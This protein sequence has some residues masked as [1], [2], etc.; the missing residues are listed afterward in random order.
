MLEKG[1][2]A[3]RAMIFWAALVGVLVSALALG[4]NR[5]VSWTA[6]WAG[7][8]MLFTALIVVDL[9]ASSATIAWRRALPALVLWTLVLVWGLIQAGPAPIAG[10]AH[11]AWADVAVLGAL[12]GVTRQTWPWEGPAEGAAV[13][14]ISADP[15]ATL[16]GVMRLSTYLMLFWIGARGATDR[17]ARGA[18]Q[19]VAL[20]GVALAI[21]GMVALFA[22][23]NPITGGEHYQ[24]TVTAS[25]VNR[26]AYAFYAGIG[27]MAC[28]AALALRLPPPRHG[29]D[30]NDARRALRDLL[31]AVIAGGWIWIVGFV[32]LL[33]AMLYTA[34]RAGTAAS[35]VGI[36]L[37]LA[38]T[39]GRRSVAWR[40]GLLVILLV[41]VIGMSLGA[42]GLFNRLLLRDPSEDGRIELFE[43]ILSAILEKP[44]LGHGLGAFQ[45]GFRPYTTY[46]L[47]IGEW[48]LAHNAYLE[49]AF[50]LGLPATTA[51]L[52]AV[53]LI[54]VRLGLGIHARQRQRP[55]PT[56]ALAI[57]V[58]G[59]LHSLVD[60]SFQMPATA[61]LAAFLTGMAWTQ[62]RREVAPGPAKKRKTETRRRR[63][64][65]TSADEP[66]HIQAN[67]D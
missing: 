11:P 42:E 9:G 39:L 2:A 23:Y 5:P 46:D 26:N 44:W 18:V 49:N 64:S 48:D 36:G 55:I 12:D 25:F 20:F 67:P 34:S 37:L 15:A 57:L 65:P 29:D 30:I 54:M 41:P 47:A 63:S 62:S 16:D 32:V 4:A 53:V 27:A 59:A 6:L 13:A 28:L 40:W 21:Y 43:R 51:L 66:T 24:G 7:S 33:A 50:E 8:A 17:S 60:F 58:A 1:R 61:A 3:M 56:L 19:V 52:L 35:L 45:D 22:D 31:E 14:S 10:W 38:L